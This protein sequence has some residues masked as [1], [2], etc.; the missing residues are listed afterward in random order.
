MNEDNHIDGLSRYAKHMLLKGFG[1]AGQERLVSSR[2]AVIGC[3]GL[4]TV[5][6]NHFVR[7]GIGCITI[8][9]R[10]YIE[11]DNLQRQMLFDEDD[12]S[13]GLP[14]AIAAARKLGRVNSQV[15]VI[16]VVT[17]INPRNI[18]EVIGNADL[19]M[20]GTDNFETRYLINDAC[21][22]HHIP[23]VYTGVI[24]FCGMT[25]LIVPHHTP[26][27]RCLM[28]KRPGPGSMPTSDTVGVLSTAV[29]VIG[30]FAVTEGLKWILRRDNEMRSYLVSVDV[31]RSELTKFEMKKASRGCPV[32]DEGIYDSLDAR[33]ETYS[34]R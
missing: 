23:W 24:S 19:V 14:K 28:D 15:T 25:M 22:K 34:A 30:A 7:A 4:G 8:V 17:D 2:V 13:R 31:W 11:L 1:K 9:D 21:V 27:F 29:D 20:D 3:G 26:C 12:I 18:E 5:I 32:C 33:E 10:D 16:P 6:S